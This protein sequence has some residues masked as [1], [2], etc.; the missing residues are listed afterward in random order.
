MGIDLIVAKRSQVA[1]R[2][3]GSPPP[4]RGPPVHL[5][6]SLRRD[7]RGLLFKSS[8]HGTIRRSFEQKATEKTEEGTGR[9]RSSVSSVNSCS[10]GQ[11]MI[12]C[13][14]SFE[15]KDA[16][17]AEEKR[18]ILCVP[19]SSFASSRF[20]VECWTLDVL[21]DPVAE[22]VGDRISHPRPRTG[23]RAGR[24]RE[25]E[26]TSP[27]PFAIG[28]PQFAIP[29]IKAPSSTPLPSKLPRACP[30]APGPCARPPARPVQ[31]RGPIGAG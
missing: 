9:S 13:V 10:K 19:R 31:I 28:Y 15:Q 6:R 17:N 8:E 29:R 30:S 2:T 18:A 3:A 24:I 12:S 1:S 25:V 20:D 14:R 26:L 11:R 7:L 5:R 23:Q 27:G 4:S 22:L 21:L 16:E